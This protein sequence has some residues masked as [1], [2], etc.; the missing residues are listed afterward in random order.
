MLT[1][2]LDPR[3]RLQEGFKPQEEGKLDVG[4]GILALLCSFEK[5]KI[6]SLFEPN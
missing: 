1:L 6:M 2:T 4:G 5:K 3:T